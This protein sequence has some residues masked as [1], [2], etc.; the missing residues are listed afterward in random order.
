[1]D[2]LLKQQLHQ[3]VD[4]SNNELLLEEAKIILQ[5]SSLKDW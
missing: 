5:D 3:L 4:D 2:A 1:M